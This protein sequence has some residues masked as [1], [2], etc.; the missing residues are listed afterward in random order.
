M[1]RYIETMKDRYIIKQ[2][3]SKTHQMG[4]AFLV[5]YH[6]ILDF[7]YLSMLFLI[8]LQSYN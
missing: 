6:C 5:V 1:M 7:I 3:A 8:W 4:S 2:S